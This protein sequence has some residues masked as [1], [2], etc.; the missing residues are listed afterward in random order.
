MEN[1]ID[2]MH[3]N[4]LN[5]RAKAVAEMQFE[6]LKKQ[7]RVQEL[8]NLFLQKKVQYLTTTLHYFEIKNFDYSIAVKDNDFK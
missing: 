8:E 5:I 6:D 7:I 2:E 3:E 1:S 4:Y